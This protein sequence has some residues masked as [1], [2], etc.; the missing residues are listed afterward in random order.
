M[1][2]KCVAHLVLTPVLS[3]SVLRQVS[4]S[5]FPSSH[6]SLLYPEPYPFYLNRCFLI[7]LSKRRKRLGRGGKESTEVR[8]SIKTMKLWESELLEWNT[9]VIMHIKTAN[10]CM[11]IM[12]FVLNWGEASYLVNFWRRFFNSPSLI[13]SECIV[14]FLLR[15]P[16]SHQKC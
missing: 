11:L 9:G 3:L 6:F 1:K 16:L 15:C 12:V 4:L 8:N 10:I 7:S 13:F 14:L 5:L 2:E